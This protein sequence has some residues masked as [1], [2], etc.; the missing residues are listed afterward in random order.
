[1]IIQSRVRYEEKYKDWVALITAHE[2]EMSVELLLGRYPTQEYAFNGIGYHMTKIGNFQNI[3]ELKQYG[4]NNDMIPFD[5]EVDMNPETYRLIELLRQR[6]EF[7]GL[8]SNQYDELLHLLQKEYKRTKE[9][10]W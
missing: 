6:E 9:L 5:D 2:E 7:C 10:D 8:P 4:L 3:R 1:M